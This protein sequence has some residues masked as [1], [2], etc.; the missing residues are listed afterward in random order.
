VRAMVW[1]NNEGKRK[2]KVQG[3]GGGTTTRSPM[4]SNE[5]DVD[6]AT[7]RYNENGYDVAGRGAARLR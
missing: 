1:S 6:V 4:R 2:Q 7:G 3:C 5:I